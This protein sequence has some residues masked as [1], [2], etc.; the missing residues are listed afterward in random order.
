MSRR[1][2]EQNP[3]YSRKRPFSFKC[4]RCD[5]DFISNH[6]GQRICTDCRLLHAGELQALSL[7][8]RPLPEIQ[9]QC[10]DCG[11]LTRKLSGAQR[12]CQG[13]R[14]LR[15]KGRPPGGNTLQLNKSGKPKDCSLCGAP[16]IRF[17]ALR[18]LCDCCR[19]AVASR[20]TL[21]RTHEKLRD[22]IWAAEYHAERREWA[23]AYR[24]KLVHLLN[25]P[26]EVEQAV[27]AQVQKIMKGDYT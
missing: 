7:L 16:F 23:N 12:Q 2:Y 1:Y 17:W 9:I 11:C 22:P 15:N 5:G 13:C 21:E 24:A 10:T 14:F 6:P 4:G 25:N 20:H 3:R 27:I 26:T 18:Q 8:K 19:R